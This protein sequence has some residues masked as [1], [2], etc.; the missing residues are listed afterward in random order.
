MPRS[1]LEVADIFH[2]HGEAWRTANTGHVTLGQLRVTS[3]IEACRTAALGGHVEQCAECSH[4]GQLRDFAVVPKAEVMPT[5]DH[6]RREPAIV[7]N[8][9]RG[10]EVCGN[11]VGTRALGSLVFSQYGK[12]TFSISTV[13][14]SRNRQVETKIRPADQSRLEPSE[15]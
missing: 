6:L 2:R 10:R 4:S 12:P 9:S 5:R 1:K 14:E 13:L 15:E 7:L 11:Q 8:H 3:A